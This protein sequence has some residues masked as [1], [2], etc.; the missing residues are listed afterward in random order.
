MK[1]Y[2]KVLLVFVGTILLLITVFCSWFFTSFKT[3]HK[4]IV[5]DNCKE[6]SVDASLVF[7]IIKAESKFNENA[8][9]SA[10]AVGL[11][12]IM[13]STANY[14]QSLN[15]KSEIT[16]EALF[17]P[18]VNIEIGTAY[19]SYLLDKFEEKDVAICAYNAGETVVKSWL[20][21]AEYS[22]D[23]K[24]LKFVPYEETRNYLQRVNF[25]QN[26]YKK[27]L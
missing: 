3:T 24:T 27:I 11:M 15:S 8:K 5:F 7:A 23:G 22:P 10:G 2:S 17:L 14:I 25:N 18:E 12:Q 21:N 16:E 6:Y 4:E 19:I 26:I 9:S 1:I 13:L 20:K